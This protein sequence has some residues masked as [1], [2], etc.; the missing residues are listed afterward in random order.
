MGMLI[1]DTGVMSKVSKSLATLGSTEQDS[2]GSSRS[3]KCE[4]IESETLSS[5]SN[6]TLACVLGEI[7]STYGKLRNFHHADIISNLSDNNSN[8][9]ILV[10]HV[11]AKTVKSNGWLVDLG[12]VKTLDNGS[13]EV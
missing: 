3:T 13:T 9:S 7:E 2:V 11:F 10:T 1:N 12:H 4:L 8:L 5:S 6:D